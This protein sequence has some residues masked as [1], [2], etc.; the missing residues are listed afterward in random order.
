[1]RYD[2][3]I[4][5]VF[6]PSLLLWPIVAYGLTALV[7]AMLERAGVYRAV[8]HRALFDLALFVCL[9]GGVIYLSSEYLS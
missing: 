1:M 7:C 4:F 9:L 8:W 5:G 6:A 2:I 3:D